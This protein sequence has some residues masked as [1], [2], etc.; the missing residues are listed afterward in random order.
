MATVTERGPLQWQ[1]KVRRKGYPVQTK[2]FDTKKEAEAWATIIESEMVRGVFVDRS[3]LERETLDELVC[4]YL[5]EETPK[6]KGADLETSRLEK[7]RR[8]ESKLC[9]YSLA[10]LRRTHFEDYRDRRSTVVA[11]GTVKR[12]LNLLHSVIEQYRHEY[13]MIENP[14]SPVKRPK[15]KDNRI[16]RF[17]E[18]EEAALMEALD[19]CR[20]PWV[21]PSVI[22]ALE[23][24]MRRGELLALRWED[25]DFKKRVAKLHDTK[26]GEWRDVPL[27]SIAVE[28]LKGLP[29][30]IEGDV[31][32]TTAEGLKNAF[33]RARKK[34]G[35]EH[36]NFHDLRHEA[37]SRLFERGWNV[38]EVAHVSGHKDLQSLKRYTNLKATDLAEKMDLTS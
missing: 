35:M 37:I 4:R 12:E 30:A 13:G 29:R 38:M 32:A 5:K 36:F 2:T 6:H 8:E 21:K 20:N 10:N 25:V 1:A 3:M 28:T 9:E 16:M 33:E 11:P 19:S 14:I 31:I 18:G 22:L 24:A 26:N 23:T 15:V 27:S 17:Q 7:F 34:A